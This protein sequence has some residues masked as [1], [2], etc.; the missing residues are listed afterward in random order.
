MRTGII[1]N[2]LM[3]DFSVPDDTDEWGLPPSEANFIEAGKRPV[4]S[5]SPTIITDR[6]GEVRLVIG[7]SGGT[8]ITTGIAYVSSTRVRG[9]ALVIVTMRM[10]VSGNGLRVSRGNLDHHWGNLCK[11]LVRGYRSRKR[12]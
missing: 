10:K 12:K 9:T 8:K 1:F 7:A 5:M 6:Q 3:S 2:N 11:Y 4:S